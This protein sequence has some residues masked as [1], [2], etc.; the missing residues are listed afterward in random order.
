MPI[1]NNNKRSK[2][3]LAQINLFAET[4]TQ[5]TNCIQEQTNRDTRSRHARVD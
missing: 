4:P 5:I 3:T 2:Q 1:N